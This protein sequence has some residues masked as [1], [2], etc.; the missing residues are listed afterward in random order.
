MTRRLTD[1]IQSLGDIIQE[2]AKKQKALDTKLKEM[3]RKAKSVP[4]HVVP[5]KAETNSLKGSKVK[6]TSVTGSKKQLTARD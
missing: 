6:Q 1:S 5:K 4:R 3:E 2:Y